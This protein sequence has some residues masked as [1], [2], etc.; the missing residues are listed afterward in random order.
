MSDSA[1]K[2]LP[3]LVAPQALRDA[4]P[5]KTFQTHVLVSPPAEVKEGEEGDVQVWTDGGTINEFA[6]DGVPQDVLKHRDGAG[7]LT[8]HLKFG[9]CAVLSITSA[10]PLSYSFDWVEKAK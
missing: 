10:Q 1:G 3:T 2:T 8:A 5:T 6:I 7:P 4:I 9:Q